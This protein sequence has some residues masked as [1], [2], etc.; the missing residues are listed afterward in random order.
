MHIAVP[1]AI[2]FLEV[3]TKNNFSNKKQFR[4]SRGRGRGR[5]KPRKSAP[6]SK[7][8]DNEVNKQSIIATEISA[9]A[10]PSMHGSFAR[11]TQRRKAAAAFND[12]SNLVPDINKY[13][14]R[15]TRFA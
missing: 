10:D 13:R 6:A 8:K 4:G 9:E 11:N 12:D 5:G 2:Q 3:I 14:K 1:I 7:R 15:S